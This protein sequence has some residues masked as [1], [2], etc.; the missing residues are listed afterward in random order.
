MTKTIAQKSARLLGALCVAAIAASPV[1]P[2]FAGQSEAELLQSL[3][4]DF[5]GRGEL[6]GESSETIACALSIE[7]SG[8]QRLSY[9]GRCVI[10]GERIPLRG[11]IRYNDTD[12]RFEASAQGAGTVVGQERNGGIAFTLGRD[13]RQGGQEGT[14]QVT[15]ALTGDSAAIGMQVADTQNGSFEGRVP[16]ARS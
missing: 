11:T 12:A 8:E 16:L 10:A 7:S 14:F 15:I 4:G 1:A 13:Y 5:T 2:A 6:V 3:T 9:S